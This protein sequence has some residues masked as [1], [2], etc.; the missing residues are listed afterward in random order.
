MSV[1]KV[2]SAVATEEKKM[3]IPKAVKHFLVNGRH[4]FELDNDTTR[5]FRKYFQYK[6]ALGL[7]QW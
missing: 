3:M 4:I 6:W 1:K 7:Y 2:T 5:T